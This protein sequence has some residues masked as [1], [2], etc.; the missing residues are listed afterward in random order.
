MNQSLDKLSLIN[1]KL[2]STLTDR[3]V[4]EGMTLEEVERLTA[5]Q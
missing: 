2:N 3:G 5:N 4:I 1:I